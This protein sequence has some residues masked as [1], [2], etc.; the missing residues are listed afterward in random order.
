MDSDDEA[1]LVFEEEVTREEESNHEDEGTFE[2][3]QPVIIPQTRKIH[4]W[5]K[6]TFIN[7][8]GHAATQLTFME[9]RKPKRYSNYDTYTTKLIKVEPFNF[10]EVF[11]HLEWTDAI[12]EE[13]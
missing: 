6:F 2:P 9:R 4:N 10:E 5:Y 3:I 8:E 1:F 12:N 11:N 13:Y 7:E